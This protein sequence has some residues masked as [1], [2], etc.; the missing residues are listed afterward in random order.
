MVNYQPLV[1]A[2]TKAKASGKARFIGITTHTYDPA[3]IRAAADAGIYDV[4]LAAYNFMQKNTEDMNKAIQYAAS[5]GVGIIAMKTQGGVRLNREKKIEVNHKAALKWALSNENICTAIPGIT[6][7]DQ[8]DLDFSVMNDLTLSEEEKKYLQLASMVRDPLYCQN[9]R[10]CIPTCPRGVEIPTL[11]RAYMYAEAYK[12][13]IQTKITL[14]EL[15]R[16]RG[17]DACRSC[18]SCSASCPNGIDIHPRLDSLMAKEF[19]LM[20]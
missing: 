16:E 15:P 13:P 11:V 17:L 4:V 10:S 18:S 6:A 20:G 1:E 9:C 12:N 7:F 19:R 5:K 8:M 14:E 3:V 2:I